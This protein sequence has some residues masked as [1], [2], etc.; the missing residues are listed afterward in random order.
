MI[1]CKLPTDGCSEITVGV[2][3]CVWVSIWPVERSQNS[4]RKKHECGSVTSRVDV[5]KP[6]FAVGELC[7]DGDHVHFLVSWTCV[8]SSDSIMGIGATR[9]AGLR[10][11]SDDVV[12]RM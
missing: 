2:G 1:T 11:S 9:E 7:P 10:S 3:S 5:R 4:C 6:L 12:P 8:P